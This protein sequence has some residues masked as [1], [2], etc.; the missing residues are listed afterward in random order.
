MLRL[1]NF[2]KNWKN[3]DTITIRK[4]GKEDRFLQNYRPIASYSLRSMQQ[5]ESSNARLEDCR[6]DTEPS[7][8]VP[9]RL[10]DRTTS[11]QSGRGNQSKIPKTGRNRNDPFI[12]R[13]DIR[14]SL[15]FFFCSERLVYWKIL[16]E[17]T[18]LSSASYWRKWRPEFPQS[19][20]VGQNLVPDGQRET[21]SRE[22]R[23]KKLEDPETEWPPHPPYSPRT[24]K[25]GNF[26]NPKD[27]EFVLRTWIS[28]KPRDFGG[29][30]PNNCQN[31][32]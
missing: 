24:S 26:K 32:G 3:A 7:I 11:G 25:P 10:R 6:E 15:E 17:A 2:P 29:E 31:D 18:S 8:C 20:T 13:K 27:V 28:T 4:K 14:H 19:H 9:K 5:R 16:G 1:R 23:R 12:C 22:N 30:D 21:S